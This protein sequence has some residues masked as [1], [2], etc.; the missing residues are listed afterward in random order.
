LNLKNIDGGY[1]KMKVQKMT[2]RQGREILFVYLPK[3]IIN[4]YDLKKGSKLS[5]GSVY[6]LHFDINV[7]SQWEAMENHRL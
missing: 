6:D 2:S 3:K 7:D 4:R 1:Q 5:L